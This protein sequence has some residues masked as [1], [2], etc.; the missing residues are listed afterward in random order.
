MYNIE[1]KEQLNNIKDNVLNKVLI[2]VQFVLL[3]GLTISFL[4][5]SQTGFKPLFAVHIFLFLVIVSLYIF[6]NKINVDLKGGIFMGSMYLMAFSGLL[7]W[8]LYG[9]GYVYI[10]PA[11]AVA[12]LYFNKKV[13]WILTSASFLI[14]I[15][16]ALLFKFKIFQFS[17]ENSDYMQSFQMWLNMI[18][19]LALVS[20]VI[21]FFWNNLF[22]MLM[23]TYSTINEQQDNMLNINDELYSAKIK[24]EESDRLKS[25]FLQ[26]I[27]HEIR[28]PLNI[29]IGFTDI[30]TQTEDE[31][32]RKELN[33]IIKTHSNQMLKIVNDIVDISKIETNSVIYHNKTFNLSDLLKEIE[34]E[35]LKRISEN[36]E[37]RINKL[38]IQLTTDRERLYQIIFNLVD[39][40][41]KFTKSGKIELNSFESG[42]KIIITVEDSGIGIEKENLEK[43]FE[44]FYKIDSF[45]PGAGLGLCLCKAMSN[46]MGGDIKVES[47]I[48]Q[49]SKFYFYFPLNIE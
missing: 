2:I 32:E 44:R 9:F 15:I 22:G 28:T 36:V 4:R 46:K 19:T 31:E 12:F 25:S 38:D 3:L 39:N 14:V 21:T 35:F 18:I 41:V 10:I 48:G 20:V 24:A 26:G 17:P 40:S 8:G 23:K 11:T 45:S 13:G 7:S 30:I 29:I 43:I 47:T 6:R 33:E 27:S 1:I 37:F 49:G 16:I 42:N 5:I 34:T